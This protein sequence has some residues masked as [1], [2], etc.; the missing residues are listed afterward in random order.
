METG[1]RCCYELA[2]FQLERIMIYGLKKK[3]RIKTLRM[4]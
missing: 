1:F 3:D 2:K 4:V